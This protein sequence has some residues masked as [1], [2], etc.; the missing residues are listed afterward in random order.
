MKNEGKLDINFEKFSGYLLGL[1]NRIAEKGSVFG[2]IFIQRQ[3]TVMLEILDRA[4]MKYISMFKRELHQLEP[5][6]LRRKI[7]NQV[8]NEEAAV[9]ELE[10]FLL[11]IWE[12]VK[13]QSPLL[14]KELEQN[15][16][17]PVAY[18]R[19]EFGRPVLGGK[20]EL[21]NTPSN[22]SPAK[23][24]KPLNAKMLPSSSSSSKK[25]PTSAS[26]IKI[27]AITATANKKASDALT[28]GPGRVPQLSADKGAARTDRNLP[29]SS[30]S[31]GNQ[32]KLQKPS[33]TATPAATAASKKPPKSIMKNTTG[34]STEKSVQKE[35]LKAEGVRF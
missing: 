1:F 31:R 10:G 22:E 4:G 6:I 28:S 2:E 13:E 18:E 29:T 5:Y 32:S 16:L 7:N 21:S 12:T 26:G 33:S 17:T 11:D 19:K 35:S 30:S 34:K 9:K 23:N 24:N 27:P 20:L 3:G 8:L 25:T 15:R 14:Y